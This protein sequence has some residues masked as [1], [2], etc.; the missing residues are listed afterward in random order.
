MEVIN[1]KDHCSMVLHHL[2]DRV[3]VSFVFLFF[4]FYKVLFLPRLSLS[5]SRHIQAHHPNPGQMKTLKDP[6]YRKDG[7]AWPY[8]IE[9]KH[10]TNWQNMKCNFSEC[11]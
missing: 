10:N 2:L 5:L 1:V 3:G 6:K 4:Q 8:N 9:I 7:Y 11:L